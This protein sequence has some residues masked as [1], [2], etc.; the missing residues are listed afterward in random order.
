MTGRV[1]AGWPVGGMPWQPVQER[2]GVAFHAGVAPAFPVTPP[3]LKFP[4]Q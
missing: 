3:K 2:V 1:S 4:W